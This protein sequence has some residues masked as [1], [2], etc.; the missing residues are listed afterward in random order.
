MSCQFLNIQNSWKLL[1][2]INNA[3]YLN[4]CYKRRA[5]SMFIILSAYVTYIV[6]VVHEGLVPVPFSMHVCTYM[7][8]DRVQNKTLQ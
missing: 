2:K 5:D 1:G 6:S 8:F 7:Q 3:L 4:L